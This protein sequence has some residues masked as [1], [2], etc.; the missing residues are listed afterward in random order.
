MLLQLMR[1]TE[2][3][4]CPQM[5]ANCMKMVRTS[6]S[7]LFVVSSSI[8]RL[9]E[10]SLV[11]ILSEFPED[12]M[13][14]PSEHLLELIFEYAAL[15]ARTRPNTL[16][17]LH[18]SVLLSTAMIVNDYIKEMLTPSVLEHVNRCLDAEEAEEAAMAEPVNAPR[19]HVD[20]GEYED[21]V[22]A[23]EQA[24]DAQGESVEGSDIEA[25][26]KDEEKDSTE[27]PSTY[28]VPRW[29]IEGSGPK[30]KRWYQ[31]FDEQKYGNTA[32]PRT[33]P[34]GDDDVFVMP[35]APIAIR[36]KRASAHAAVAKMSGVAPEQRMD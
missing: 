36:S 28:K 11:V 22:D 9:T 33:A 3:R 12:P 5:L 29:S 21:Y 7:S 17:T 31:D 24:E 2:S 30:L 15:K 32:D 20:M 26:I 27:L 13:P 25:M 18:P 16:H 19:D 1:M 34:T 4:W 14:M 23:D 10:I 6:S 35:Q 8:L